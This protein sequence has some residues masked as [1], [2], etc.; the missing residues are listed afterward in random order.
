ML[1]DDDRTRLQIRIWTYA[2]GGR[3]K[4]NE[5]TPLNP[6]ESTV[7][8]VRA[9]T[10]AAWGESGIRA[11]L[12]GRLGPE[13]AEPTRS[14]DG[15]PAYVRDSG[16]CACTGRRCTCRCVRAFGEGDDDDQA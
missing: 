1:R 5:A 13:V 6:P 4:W 10:A 9:L 14:H 7:E 15:H 11:L 12:E 8:V 2:R 3:N 16:R